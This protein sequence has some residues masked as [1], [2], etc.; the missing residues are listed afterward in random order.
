MV[1]FEGLAKT[2]RG[3]WVKVC[4][5]SI[6]LKHDGFLYKPSL[7]GGIYYILDD[8]SGGFIVIHPWNFC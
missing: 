1:K 3:F 6:L 7:L 4:F 8:T 2:R 5:C